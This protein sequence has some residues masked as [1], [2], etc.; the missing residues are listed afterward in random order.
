MDMKLIA[1]LAILDDEARCYR[2][3][4]SVL[5]DEKAS[6]SLKRNER[7][8]QVQLQKEALVV[9]LQRHEKKRKALVDR[10]AGAYPLD[11]SNPT[12]NLTVSN[13]A[14]YLPAPHKANLLS[15]VDCLKS[16]MLEVQA[17]NKENQQSI[18]H[19]LDLNGGALKLLTGLMDDDSVYQKPGID[20][21]ALGYGSGGG[22]IICGTA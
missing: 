18:R 13:L 9:E 12:A 20:H 16:S 4:K 6:L 15:R 7:F 17:I 1:L 19:Y 11:R 22:R 8:D 14:R 10:L 21:S 5:A 3:M 2:D